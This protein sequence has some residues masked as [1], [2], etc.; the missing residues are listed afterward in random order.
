[1][2]KYRV[3]TKAGKTYTVWAE[4]PHD[5]GRIVLNQHGKAN[6]GS[7]VEVTKIQNDPSADKR[8]KGHG[9]RGW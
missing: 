8:G 1:M 7:G 3:K 5:A 4:S 9:L 6:V 2:P